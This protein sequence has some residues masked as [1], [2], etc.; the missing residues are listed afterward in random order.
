MLFV[1]HPFGFSFRRMGVHL[2]G[3]FDTGGPGSQMA[4]SSIGRGIGNAHSLESA[5][6]VGGKLLAL[7][8]HEHLGVVEFLAHS[9]R[10]FRQLVTEP[11]TVRGCFRHAYQGIAGTKLQRHFHLIV[12]NHTAFV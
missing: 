8:S 12:R 10:T 5:R 4:G 3:R 9:E 6:I 7:T 11:L 2:A 1:D